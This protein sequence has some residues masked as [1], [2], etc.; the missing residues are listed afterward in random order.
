MPR[1]QASHKNSLH[2]TEKHQGNDEQ[3]LLGTSE[4][5]I[6]HQLANRFGRLQVADDGHLRYFGATSHL[7]MMPQELISFYQ[8]SPRPLREEGECAV[9]RAGLQWT[10]DQKYE[11]HLTAL[12]FAWH[13]PYVNEV[14]QQIYNRERDV[15][16]SGRDTPLYT[17]ALNNAM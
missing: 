8:P 13:N 12:Y 6:A 7:H 11:N 3:M 14:D 16:E 15:Y 17:P 2:R 4:D 10:P 5:D 9:D 1:G